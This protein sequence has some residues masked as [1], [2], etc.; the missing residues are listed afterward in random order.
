MSNKNTSLKNL[1]NFEPSDLQERLSE[2]ADNYSYDLVPESVRNIDCNLPELGN[3][4]L[5]ELQALRT[6][7]SS[8]TKEL[9]HIRYENMKLN[10]QID[11]LNKTIG[12][13]DE[14]LNS[15]RNINAELKIANETLKN[16]NN[17]YWRNTFIV[18]FVVA[19]IFFVLGY[20]I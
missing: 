7:V 14:E 19:A 17:H 8:Q 3:P 20:F 5:E 1:I 18:G 6:E 12:S 9:Q 16:S 11:T 4:M 13:K 2:L 10:A 15:L